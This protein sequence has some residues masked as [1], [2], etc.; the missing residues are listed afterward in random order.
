MPEGRDRFCRGE[1]EIKDLFEVLH[2]IFKWC[3]IS[4]FHWDNNDDWELFYPRFYLR[5]RLSVSSLMNIIVHDDSIRLLVRF[6]HSENYRRCLL[7]RRIAWKLYRQSIDQL[8]QRAWSAFPSSLRSSLSHSSSSLDEKVIWK[9]SYD[10][11]LRSS[12]R[13]M[14]KITIKIW[15]TFFFPTNLNDRS[16]AMS[17][18]KDPLVSVT[19]RSMNSVTLFRYHSSIM[20]NFF[21]CFFDSVAVEHY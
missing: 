18:F 16:W 10:V 7:F 5:S 12:F 13:L 8:S 19:F 11:R 9:R 2:Q 3:T 17:G 21:C 1:E 15:M 6:P 20:K 14:E 4:F